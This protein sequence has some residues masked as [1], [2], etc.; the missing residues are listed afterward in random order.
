MKIIRI[1]KRKCGDKLSP[2]IAAGRIYYVKSEDTLMDGTPVL[3][4]IHPTDKKKTIRVNRHRF[5]WE[6]LSVKDLE[7]IEFA[8]KIKQGAKDIQRNFTEQ[9]QINIAIVPMI[10][11][12]IAWIYAEKTLQ[13]AASYRIEK[14]KKLGRAVRMLK[15][16]YKHYISKDL[17]Q[18]EVFKL[19]EE[20]AKFVEEN[21]KD[22]TI[23]YFAINQ[24]LKTKFPDYPYL[25]L[26][27]NAI[28]SMMIISLLDAYN[29][30]M[31]KMVSKRMRKECV[32]SL[33]LPMIDKLYTCMDAYA[34]EI[35]GFDF[36][37]KNI[38]MSLKV[39]E[40][41]IKR[42]RFEVV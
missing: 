40:N 39:I 25:D 38:I 42:V 12:G 11:N 22:F 6:E 2:L 8:E 20:T 5:E 30:E 29:I 16:E 28:I 34:G 35:G 32:P 23:L 9:E 19:E 7:K 24:E 37:A 21:T 15:E 14:L 4:V 13:L 31:D 10:F 27:T 1:S 18:K 33:R 41:N 36:K 17:P 3:N 26:R